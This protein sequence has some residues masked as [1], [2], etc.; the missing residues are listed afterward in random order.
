MTRNRNH[1]LASVGMR[2]SKEC[3]NGFINFF[4]SGAHPSVMEAVAGNVG[5]I[6]VRIKKQRGNDGETGRPGQTDH[7]QTSLS[8]RGGYGD[9]AVRDSLCHRRSLWPTM[10]HTLF[11][12]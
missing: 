4:S 5:K 2:S 7:P 11:T 8:Q 1:I 6:K 12:Y 10:V 9:N 3:Q